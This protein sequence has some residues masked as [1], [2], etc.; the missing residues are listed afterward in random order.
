MLYSALFDKHLLS[1]SQNQYSKSVFQVFALKSE[2]VYQHLNDYETYPALKTVLRC[3]SV[4]LRG[5]FHR[6]LNKI[7]VSFEQTFKTKC[8]VRVKQERRCLRK[9]SKADCTS[10]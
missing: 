8:N 1:R 5:N 9:E 10:N 6:A 3:K 7:L 4:E 2:L